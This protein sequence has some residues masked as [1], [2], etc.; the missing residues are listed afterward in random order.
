MKE[1]DVEPKPLVRK[2]IKNNKPP[3]SPLAGKKNSSLR[4][5]K[6]GF[7]VLTDQH[8]LYR[9]FGETGQEKRLNDAGDDFSRLFEESQTDGR[10]QHMMQEKLGRLPVKRMPPVPVGERVKVYPAPQRELDLHGFTSRRAAASVEMFIGKS[11]RSEIQTV[12]VIVGKGLHSQ[13]RA[14]LPDVVER[15][16]AELKR[17]GQVLTY[18]WEKKDKRKSGSLIVYLPD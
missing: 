10:Q 12:R 13:G 5:D 4:R 9:L 3:G 18:R 2:K 15:K 8:D 17:N 16:L 14:V 11:I 1:K 6:K 7:A